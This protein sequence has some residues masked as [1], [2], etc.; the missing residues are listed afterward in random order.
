MGGLQFNIVHRASLHLHNNENWDVS[1]A[2]I[3]LP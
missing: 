3:L 1:L 2:N